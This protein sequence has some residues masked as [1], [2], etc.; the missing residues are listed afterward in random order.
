MEND[1]LIDYININMSKCIKTNEEDK[2][3]KQDN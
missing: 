2:D 1:M 3:K